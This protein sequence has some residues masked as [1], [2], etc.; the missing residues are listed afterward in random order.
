MRSIFNIQEEKDI[1]I[2]EERF[3]LAA[4][5]EGTIQEIKD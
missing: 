3:L 1:E 4:E 2:P 5:D